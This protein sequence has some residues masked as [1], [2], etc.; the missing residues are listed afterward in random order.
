MEERHDAI[1]V[2]QTEVIG[3]KG[4]DL[5]PELWDGVRSLALLSKAPMQESIRL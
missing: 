4:G 2:L 3:E 1:T 5:V